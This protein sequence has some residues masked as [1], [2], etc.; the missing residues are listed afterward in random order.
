MRGAEE[1]LLLLCCKLGQPVKPLTPTEY[2]QMRALAV[3]KAPVIGSLGDVTPEYLS[4]LGYSEDMTDR[5]LS[6]LNRPRILRDYLAAQKDVCVITRLDAE[7]FPRRLRR[8][9]GDCPATLFCRGDIRLLNTRC[10]AAVG[11]RRLLS[12]GRAFAQE[13]GRRAA[14][15]GFTL[16]SGNAAGADSAAQDACLQ[17]GGRVVCFVPDELTRYAPRENVLYCSADGYDLPFSAA[18]ALYRNLLIHALGEKTFVAQ[19]PAASGGTWS[20]ASENLKRGLS[21]VYVLDDGSKGADA[22]CALGASPVEDRLPSIGALRSR[23]L[24]IFD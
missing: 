15:E 16:V 1:G 20:G 17:A 10:V 13:V 8:L 24:S 9:G 21:D 12:R 23:Q 14:E 7:R 4:S 19:C 11:S 2:L 5:I 22:L 18:R 3:A 6:L